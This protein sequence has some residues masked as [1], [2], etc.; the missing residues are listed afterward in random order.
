MTSGCNAYGMSPRGGVVGMTSQ[1]E[2]P[3][4][5]QN[6]LESFLSDL[7]MPRDPLGGTFGRGQGWDNFP[8][9]TAAP[10]TWSWISGRR[11]HERTDE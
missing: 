7:G 11:L 4:Q 5:T 2:N 9:E 10:V 1:E 8:T 6:M 3:G